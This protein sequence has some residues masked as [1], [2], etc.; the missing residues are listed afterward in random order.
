[1][2]GRHAGELE[3]WADQATGEWD[4]NKVTYKTPEYML[5]S[6]QDYQPGEAGYQQHIWQAT[7]NQNAVVFV[8]HPACVSED[9]AH[10]PNFWHGNVILPRVAQWKDLLVAVHNMPDD[11]WMGF[12]HAYFPTYAFDNW[13]TQDGWAFAQVG[14]GYLAL[15]AS[16]GIELITSGD[17]AYRELR[18]YGTQNVWLCMMGRKALDGTCHEFQKKILKL[19]I[20]LSAQ[21]V[22]GDTLRGETVDFGWQGPLLVNEI[23]QPITD[24]KHYDSPLCQ[25]EIGDGLMEI[26]LGEQMMRL[27]F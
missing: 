26:Q 24:F 27:K 23:D 6:A 18:S 11:D 14:E 1:M 17:N 20:S 4:V 15:T 8:T 12:T 10:R 9:G 25:A 21:S 16:R 22:H 19:D 2:D 13:K 7:F 5:C 3:A